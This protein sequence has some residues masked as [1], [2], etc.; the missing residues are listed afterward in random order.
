MRTGG[1]ETVERVLGVMPSPCTNVLVA[2][3]VER[4]PEK[5]EGRGFESSSEH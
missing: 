5:A 1:V 4:S 3:L 2:Q